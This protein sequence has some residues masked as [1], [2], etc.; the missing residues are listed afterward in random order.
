MSRTVGVVGL[1]NMGLGMALNLVKGGF[2]VQGFDVRATA[3]DALTEGGGRGV[4]S[5]AAAGDGA[6][7]V[8]IM[9]MNA[10]QAEEVISGENGLLT[11]MKPGSAVMLSATIGVNPARELG[12]TLQGH[13]IET[14]DCCVSGGRIGADSG[15]LALMAGGPTATFERLGDVLAAVGDRDKTTHVGEAVGDGQAAKACVQALITISYLAVSESMVLGAGLNLDAETLRHVLR[16][17]LAGS[18]LVDLIG[19]NVEQ[20]QFVGTGSHI[21]TLQKDMRLT[22]ETA[23]DAAVALPITALATQF[24]EASA[25]N[26][27]DEDCWALEKFFE[28]IGG[29]KVEARHAEKQV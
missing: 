22:M 10:A 7:V 11:T 29:V 3:R 24:V 14:L 9:V 28:T 5:P 19:K 15:S 18:P 21:S 16:G 23:R 6:D 26:Y 4:N 17:S 12:R 20:R 27:P 8:V 1:G 25:S 13:G 2:D